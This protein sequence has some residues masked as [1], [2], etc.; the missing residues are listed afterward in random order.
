MAPSGHFH[1]NYWL[2]VGPY[3]GRT[4]LRKIIMSVRDLDPRNLTVAH[5]TAFVEGAW[6]FVR[7]TLARYTADHC[8]RIAA[9]LSYTSLLALVPL[10]AIGLAIMA[11]FP[12]LDA[13]RQQV[14][15]LA[16]TSVAPHAGDTV[17]A[18]FET[19]VN[20]TGQLTTIG[21]VGIAVTA[22]MLLATIEGAFNV[23]W[24]VSRPRAVGTRLV[25]YWTVLTL[26]PLLLAVGVSSSSYVNSLAN[27]VAD[28]AEA[29][30]GD[31]EGVLGALPLFIETVFFSLL[32]VALPNRRVQWR[33]A[34]TGGLVAA[35][36]FEILKNVFAAYIGRV[37]TF[38]AVYGTLSALPLFLIWMYFAWSVV[39]VGAVVAAAWPEW[40]AH[41]RRARF[42]SPPAGR[43][44]A[45]SLQ[46]L[47]M[48][49][50]AGRDGHGVKDEALL[51]A[52][53]G[54]SVGLEAAVAVLSGQGLVART[55]DDDLVL[56]RDLDG[57]S[58]YDIYRAVGLGPVH[59]D[60][61]DD[62][63]VSWAPELRA[64][65]ADTDGATRT[66]LSTPVKALFAEHKPATLSRRPSDTTAP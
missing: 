25:A 54:D 15:Q 7:Y 14:I 4:M 51:A 20:N 45:L 5:V 62:F 65:L 32:Y 6:G 13:V 58:L 41:R 38:Q 63:A 66:A 56:A 27:F 36:L 29:V 44:F 1:N 17:A 22:V 43:R 61:P 18:Y 47:G 24:R 42:E 34:L 49:L 35:I 11:A 10:A 12:A 31:R 50:G 57:V 9:A 53:G 3:N 59:D 60:V 30:G 33:H 55:D 52:F 19:F 8:L 48:L 16:L 26:G 2:T 40:L 39:L 37:V 23:I 28:S 21:I 46:L 64:L